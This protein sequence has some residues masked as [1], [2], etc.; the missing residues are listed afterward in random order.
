MKW[1]EQAKQLMNGTMGDSLRSVIDSETGRNLAKAFNGQAV[2]QAAKEGD[3]KALS[4]LLK[5]VLE[6]PEGKRFAEQIQRTV[7]NGQ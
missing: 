5:Q 3:T 1:E 2:E 7:N 6:T 4:V